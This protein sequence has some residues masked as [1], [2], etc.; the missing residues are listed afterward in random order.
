MD[1]MIRGEPQWKYWMTF[2]ERP[3]SVKIVEICSTMVGVCGEGFSMTELPARI[4]GM[5]ELTRIK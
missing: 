1:S 4:A 5:R 2:C 3:A